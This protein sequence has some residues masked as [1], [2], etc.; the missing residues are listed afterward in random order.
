MKSKYLTLLLTIFVIAACSLSTE[1]D[2]PL[3]GVPSVPYDNIEYPLTSDSV[4]L[5]WK[6]RFAPVKITLFDNSDAVILEVNY[7]DEKIDSF[8]DSVWVAKFGGLKPKDFYKWQVIVKD[9]AN[10]LVT[11][12][13]W[14]FQFLPGGIVEG[15]VLKFVD[16]EILLPHNVNLFFN[17]FDLY[18]NGD[19][20]KSRNDFTISDDGV[21]PQ[22][23]EYVWDI[24]QV[25]PAYQTKIVLILDASYSVKSSP[26]F[27]K[28]KKEAS[29]FIEKFLSTESS[30]KEIELW[31]FSD[32]VEKLV[33]FTSDKS[34]LLSAVNS[35]TDDVRSTNLFGA[36]IEGSESWRKIIAKDKITNTLVIVFTDGND[37]QGSK[38]LGEARNAVK[39]KNVILVNTDESEQYKY[40]LNELTTY[41]S[42]LKNDHLEIID[43]VNDFH[44]SVRLTSK[45]LYQLIYFSPKRG[46][47]THDLRVILKDSGYQNPGSILNVQYSSDG[48][49]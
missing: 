9:E 37:T 24:K 39:E 41:P 15:R 23:E 33:E 11:G 22:D 29:D 6:S 4:K 7:P 3:N 12:P 47:K 21:Q 34:V 25:N 10:N 36:V 49:Y 32:K 16:K 20:T 30:S 2:S 28:M 14:S 13:V 42:Y 1:P 27:V 40:Y 43:F 31:K 46:N 38:T 45:S 44:K 26:E 18:Y 19:T 48:F 5:E 17:V 35:I 8:S